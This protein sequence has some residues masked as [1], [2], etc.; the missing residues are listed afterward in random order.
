MDYESEVEDDILPIFRRGEDFNHGVEC[1][2]LISMVETTLG[3][4][5]EDAL[6]SLRR[7]IANFQSYIIQATQ[8]SNFNKTDNTYTHA[9]VIRFPSLDAL[10][11]FTGSSEY[12][13]MWRHKFRPITKKALLTYFA[14]D[15]VGTQLM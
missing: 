9:A 3:H 7:L 14:V 15:P 1:I 2:L 12:K 8:G 6:A 4:A 10:E 11:A 13:E 5:I